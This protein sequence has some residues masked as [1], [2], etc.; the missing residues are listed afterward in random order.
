MHVS[1]LEHGA[2]TEQAARQCP[3]TQSCPFAQSSFPVHAAP[4]DEGFA[5]TPAL[6]TWP[7][8]HSQ[9]CVQPGLADGSAY[10]HLPAEV[11][12]SPTWQSR[13]PWQMG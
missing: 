2:L 8:G 4:S 9:L 7:L 3:S 1:A 11:Q 13:S 5:Q 10:S 12:T 6:H